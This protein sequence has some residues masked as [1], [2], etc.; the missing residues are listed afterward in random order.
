MNTL[1]I[2]S[3]EFDLFSYFQTNK[4]VSINLLN[5]D[6]DSIET[7]VNDS[8]TVQIGDEYKGYNLVLKSITKE[9]TDQG[10]TYRV[11]LHDAG[12]EKLIEQAQADIE[13]NSDA[14]AELAEIIGG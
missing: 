11:E 6:I 13:M 14:I 10:D 9:Y 1:I 5:T 3:T 8:A 12:V 7:A 4:G 2:N